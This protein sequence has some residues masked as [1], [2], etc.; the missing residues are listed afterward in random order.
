ML[1]HVT[2]THAPEKCP[3]YDRE[4]LQAFL[5]NLKRGDGLSQ[6]H[7]VKLLFFLSAAPVHEFYALIETNRAETIG[8][9]LM[10]LIPFPPSEFKVTPVTTLEGLVTAWE[11][12]EETH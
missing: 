12:A 8:R 5:E 2:M 1:F 6:E 11:P 4:M 9:F 10:D 3:G 7:G